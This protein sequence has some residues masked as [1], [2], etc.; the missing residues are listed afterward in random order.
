V[1]DLG[2]GTGLVGTALAVSGAEIIGVD[3]SPRML[4]IAAN[5]GAYTHLELGELVEV[6]GR[7]PADSVLTVLA[8]DV[9]IYVGNLEAVFGEVAR[10]L[11]P[12]GLFAMSVE[13]LDEGSYQLRPT[14]RYAQS[15]DYLS[16][17]SAQCGLHKRYLERTRIRREGSTRIEGWIALFAKPGSPAKTTAA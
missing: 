15:A 13:G 14:G 16:R 11:A 17:L 6:L 10:V 5:C 3:L 4:Q 7:M 1:V 12:G 8:A 9:F 2:C